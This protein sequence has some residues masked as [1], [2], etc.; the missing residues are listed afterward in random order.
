MQARGARGSL[1]REKRIRQNVSFPNEH[2]V[3]FLPC[4]LLRYISIPLPLVP[5]RQV[6]RH[7]LPAVSKRRGQGVFL[8]HCLAPSFEI[9]GRAAIQEVVDESSRGEEIHSLLVGA[10]GRVASGYRT[11]I[12]MVRSS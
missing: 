5:R 4:F 6:V 12:C 9:G 2:R 7:V 3:L 8:L 10:I 11:Y 1:A